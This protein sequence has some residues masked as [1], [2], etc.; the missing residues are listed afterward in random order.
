MPKIV[1]V[2]RRNNIEIGMT[3]LTP[4]PGRVILKAIVDN[5]ELRIAGRL[6]LFILVFDECKACQ[7]SI[8][9]L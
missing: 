5:L 7:S 8:K 1:I 3:E 4:K 2:G 6:I 9:H